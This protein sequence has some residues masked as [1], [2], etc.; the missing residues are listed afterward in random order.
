MFGPKYWFDSEF[1]DRLK[2]PEPK[3]EPDLFGGFSFFDPAPAAKPSSDDVQEARV[4][5]LPILLV[6]LVLSLVITI[7]RIRKRSRG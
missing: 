4:Q 1:R 5:W 2:P 6:V 3:P 7:A